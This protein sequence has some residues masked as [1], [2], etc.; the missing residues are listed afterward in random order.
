M[1]DVSCVEGIIQGQRVIVICGDGRAFG[2]GKIWKDG[3]T[4]EGGPR[5]YI[6]TSDEYLAVWGRSGAEHPQ[7]WSPLTR[8]HQRANL[9]LYWLGSREP[10]LLAYKKTSAEP[11]HVSVSKIFSKSV[12]VVEQKVSQRGKTLW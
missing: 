8:D 10:E 9:H 2:H 11:L 1:L 5:R 4:I 7:P 6:N 12:I 3:W